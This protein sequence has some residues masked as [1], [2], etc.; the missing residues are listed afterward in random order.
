M[1]DKDENRSRWV[2]II[3]VPVVVVLP[4][5]EGNCRELVADNTN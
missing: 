3:M 5:R 2:V 4:A 1:V